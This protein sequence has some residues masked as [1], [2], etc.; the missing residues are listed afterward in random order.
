MDLYVLPAMSCRVVAAPADL[1]E[2]SRHHFL[3]GSSADLCTRISGAWTVS[4]TRRLRAFACRSLDGRRVVG[5]G[6]LV[7]DLENIFV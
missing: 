5:V 2:R 3:L 4:S 6:G 1:A 7:N